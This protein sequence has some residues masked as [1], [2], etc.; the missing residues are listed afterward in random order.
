[1]ESAAPWSGVAGYSSVGNSWATIV[2]EDSTTTPNPAPPTGVA[3]DCAIGYYWA[4]GGLTVDAA[5]MVGSRIANSRTVGDCWAAAIAGDSTATVCPIAAYSAF[6]DKGVAI[7]AV[8]S[9]SEA[10]DAVTPW[11]F[12][13]SDSTVGDY[14]AAAGIAIDSAAIFSKVVSD[15]AVFN[16][17]VAAI[18]AADSAATVIAQIAFYGAVDNRRAACTTEY[19]TSTQNPA[20]FNVLSRAITVSNG[21]AVYN[22]IF[23]FSSV[24]VEAAMMLCFCTVAVDDAIFRAGF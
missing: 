17:W 5:A 19:S 13:A 6:C 7:S 1:M 9:T 11:T 10:A 3:A 8:D 24:E 14:G 2:A 15:G 22:G 16:R 23:I 12:V 20:I 21:Q 4:A 18:G